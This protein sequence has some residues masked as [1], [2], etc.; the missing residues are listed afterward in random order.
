MNEFKF[1]GT[2]SA[3]EVKQTKAGKQFATFTMLAPDSYDAERQLQVRMTAFGKAAETVIGLGEF[4]EVIASGKI[5][6][7]EWQ[8][9]HYLDLKALNIES[10]GG[11]GL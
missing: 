11:V 1:S 8:G 3:L 2:I 10:V 5:D 9:K 4:A 7:R 6:S